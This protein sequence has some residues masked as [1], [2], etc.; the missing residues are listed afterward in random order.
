MPKLRYR[1]DD[2]NESFVE[3]VE[4][5]V[6]IVFLLI[7]FFLVASSFSSEKKETVDLAE[8]HQEQGL[9]TGTPTPKMIVKNDF[10]IVVYE[11]GTVKIDERP[12]DLIDPNSIELYWK[13]AELIE[14]K[15]QELARNPH[16]IIDPETGEPVVNVQ[17]WTDKRAYSGMTMH[18]IMACLDKDLKPDVLFLQQMEPYPEAATPMPPVLPEGAGEAAG[19]TGAGEAGTQP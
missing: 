9:L 3:G 15:K 16:A 19:E 12:V 6:D 14:R 11:D 4:G 18:C 2:P 17:V 1:D 13:C 7:I 8:R 5:A 10:R